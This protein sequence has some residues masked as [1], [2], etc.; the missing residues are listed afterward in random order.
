[1]KRRINIEGMSCNHCVK[2]VKEALEE[3]KGVHTATVD[4]NG[5]N[6]VVELENESVTDAELKNAIE[7]AGYDV[8]SVVN[9]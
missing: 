4:L 6:A 9:L 2:H 5:K 1:M 7:E 3:I 8:I